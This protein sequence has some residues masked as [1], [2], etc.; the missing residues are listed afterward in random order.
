M[1]ALMDALPGSSIYLDITGLS[2]H[3]WAPLLRVALTTGKL[4]RAV[5]VEPAEYRFSETPTEGEIFDL[6]EAIL[7]ISPLPGFTSLA[8]PRHADSVCFVPLLGFEGNRL[9][10][11]LEMVQP[12]GQKVIPIVGVPGFRP[13]YPFYTYMGNRSAL[14]GNLIWSRIRY[15]KANCPFSLFYALEDISTLYPDELLKIAPIGT[16]PHALGAVLYALYASRAVELVYDHPV[17]KVNRTVGS[18]NIHVYDVSSMGTLY[19]ARL[20]QEGGVA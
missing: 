5:Y 17:R 14:E 8:Q 7:G 9:Q 20:L 18:A 3:V 4:V 10:Y 11:V 2:H 19:R 6:S 13:E 12:P 16:K 1:A 15:A